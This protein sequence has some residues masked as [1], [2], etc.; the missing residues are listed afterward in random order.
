MIDLEQTKLIVDVISKIS[1]DAT[2]AVITFLVIQFLTPVAKSSVI[3]FTVYKVIRA[4]TETF[5]VTKRD[6]K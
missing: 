2:S 4:I 5:K 3:G 6:S 1:G